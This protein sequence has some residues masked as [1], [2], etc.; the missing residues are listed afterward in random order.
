MKKILFFL[1]AFLLLVSFIDS[2][3]QAVDDW[4]WSHPRPGGQT[5]RWCQM[6]NANT[7]YAVGY[8]GNFFKT[9]NG[10]TTWKHTVCSIPWRGTN[11]TL[12]DAH[13]FNMNTGVVAGY[14]EIFRTTDGGNTWDTCAG[15][16][17]QTS[18]HYKFSFI[19]SNTGF[20]AGASGRVFKTTNAG[21]SWTPTPDPTAG[22]S[23]KYS[24]YFI[25]AN[26]GMVG[27]S[28]ADIWRTTNGGANWY[29]IN[30]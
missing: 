18:T 21:V 5:L 17:S 3:A 4:S 29:E 30:L 25:N 19:N 8:G 20:V 15:V 28:S 14:K 22:T 1:T 16:T 9:T 2:N 12:Y 23:S 11:S 13:F 24:C 26:T 27:E 6:F 10:G 7:Y